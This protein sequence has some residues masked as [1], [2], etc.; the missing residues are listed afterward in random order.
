MKVAIKAYVV[1]LFLLLLVFA[2]PAQND[3]RSEKDDRNPAPTFGTGGPVG[4]P[5]GLFTVYDSQTLRKGEFTLS[6]TLSNYDRDPGD[7][8]ITSYPLSF[9]WGLSN[10]FELFLNTEAYRQ[11]KVNSPR[12]LSAFYLPNSQLLIGTNL[13]SGPAIVLAPQGGI[14]T[15]LAG[16]AVFR[17]AG[18]A[19]FGLF[20]FVGGS[21]GTFGIPTTGTIFSPGIAFGFCATGVACT[22]PVTLGPVRTTTGSGADLFPGIGSIYGSLLPG[23]VFT[24]AT[25]NNNNGGVGAVG[26][27]SFSA[28]PIYL[29]DAPFVARQWGTSSFNSLTGGF[30]WRFN[31]IRDGWGHG[32]TAFY[33]WY[34]DKADDSTGFNMMQRGSGPGRKWGDIGVTYFADA[35]V[36]KWANVS[37][38]I[39]YVFTTQSKA[40]IGGTEYTILDPG[41]EFQ[42]AVGAD[43]PVNRYFQ[44]ILEARYLRYVG[45][46][47]PNGLEQHPFDTLAGVRIFPARWWGI[48]LGWRYN[49]NQ[50]DDGFFG[51]NNTSANVTLRC[52]PLSATSCT[53]L[54]I[55]NNFSGVPPGVRTSNDPHGYFLQFFVGR[56][57]KRA[58]PIVNQ[59]ANVES[60]TLGSTTITLPCPPGQ[61]SASGC[62]DSSRSISV[63]TVARDPENDVLTYNYTVSGG[64]VVGTGANVQWDLTTAQPGT[65]TITAGVD[66]G[67]G[68]CGATKTQTITIRNC[69]DCVTPVAPCN[70][71]TSVDVSGPSGTSQLNQPM[72]FTASVRGGDGNFNLTYNWTVSTG[73]I[74]SGQGTQ[75]I[76]V[77]TTGVAGGTN[78]TATVSV[79]VSG[80]GPS[81][82]CGPLSGSET[83]GIVTPPISTET[84]VGKVPADQLKANL[85]VY[86]TSL[87]NDPTARGYII[88]YGTAAEIK[89]RR[90]DVTAAAK[91]RNFD[92]SRIT[93]VDAPG[94][95]PIRSRLVIVPA[96]AT[97]PNP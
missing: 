90:A 38:N 6:A 67:C 75:S 58:G 16:T 5:T 1:T 32:I 72:T 55:A 44:P 80:G 62:A 74:S 65:Y 47:T 24:T 77:D 8:D 81:C 46:R 31:S 68:V 96:G 64:R 3:K 22:T 10:H 43:F 25:I 85:D 54:S 12:N 57:D 30:K 93:F 41:D 56:R 11:I 14:A 70:C 4:G 40:N 15:G 83:A 88:N 91:F 60:L 21:A 53:T 36:K 9:N 78:V 66:D 29:P 49:V 52:G 48:S 33:R 26:P 89:K 20:P 76:T 50:Q 17:P 59:P 13:T 34:M 63:T 79:G 84:E 39:G 82:N 19:P 2:V 37:A 87:G 28:A 86:F 35:R 73:T 23:V 45:G 61:T 97:P 69:P 71:P 18:T 7:V 42:A 95:G 51:N 94:A 92:M 27:V